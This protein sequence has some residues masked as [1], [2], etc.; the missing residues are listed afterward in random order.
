MRT[1]PFTSA[2]RFEQAIAVVDKLPVARFML[3]RRWAELIWHGDYRNPHTGTFKE[4][5][6]SDLA[7][8]T[9]QAYKLL[10]DMEQFPEYV[11]ATGLI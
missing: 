9:L 8:Y 10:L 4:L 1:A 7:D 11:R 5:P 2:E 6:R 3:V